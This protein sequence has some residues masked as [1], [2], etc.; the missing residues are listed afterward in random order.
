MLKARYDPREDRML[1]TIETQQGNRVFW[2]TR[3]MWLGLY[4]RLV[5][6]VAASEDDKPQTPTVPQPKPATAEES[7]AAVLLEGAQ[8]KKNEERI[9]IVFQSA[10]EPVTLQLGA[11][12]LARVKRMI[13]VQADR[14]GW[15]TAAAL[16]R[17][18]AAAAAGA[19]VR[20][21]KG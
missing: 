2:V 16:E 5:A 8:F 1:L 9:A 6:L 20:Q 10:G 14:A 13:E 21:A 12:G 4:R 19:A 11:P 7:A 17:L 15:D 3:P 18:E